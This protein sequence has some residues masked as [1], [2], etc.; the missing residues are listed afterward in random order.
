MFQNTDQFNQ[1]LT[2]YAQGAYAN[3]GE[4]LD[5]SRLVFPEVAVDE[6]TGT[7]DIWSKEVPFTPV[8]AALARNQS[9]HRI[10]VE[11]T[12][13]VFNCVPQALEI[14][15]WAP[16]LLQKSGP[17]YREASL[18]TLMSA[19]F[20]TRQVEAVKMLNTAVQAES[21]L[22]IDSSSDAIANID[23][24]CEKV[25]AGVVGRRP[26]ALLM[27]RE[28][29]NAIRN[30]ASVKERCHALD[31]AIS[32]EAFVAALAYQGIKLYI[33]D[34]YA[35]VGSAMEAVLGKDVYALYNEEAPGLSDLSFGK[36]FTLSPAGPEVLSYKDRA[37]YDVDVLMWSSDR[38]VTNAAAAAR[39]TI[40]A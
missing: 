4:D 16:T 3:P 6:A 2:N 30:H 14:A 1:V 18:R 23:A 39:L 12:T 26:T 34:L 24:L 15:N 5:I 7:Y 38:Q 17:R 33:S 25:A 13:G 19:Q 10:E 9:P 8:D 21:A 32:P 11:R 29:W 28:A 40:S 37:V 35:K 27:S 22:A 31:Y 36:E 20:I